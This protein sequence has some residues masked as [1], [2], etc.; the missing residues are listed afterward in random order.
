[1]ASLATEVHEISSKIGILPVLSKQECA[2]LIERA[3]VL[4]AWVDAPV[5]VAAGQAEVKSTA[6]LAKIIAQDDYPELFDEVYPA[7][8]KRLE[9]LTIVG[10]TVRY[11]VSW[12]HLI[13]YGTNGHFIPHRDAFPTTPRYVW[14][15]LSL[16]CYLNDSFE[17]G[18][19]AFPTIGMKLR[20]KIGHAVLFPST[21]KHGG[22]V[23]TAGEKYILNFYL[24]DP[25]GIGNDTPPLTMYCGRRGQNPQIGPN[26]LE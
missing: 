22:N 4:Q 23:V 15:K 8:E 7:I 13:R 5:H 19:T 2:R 21:Y 24:G 26:G 25:V 10:D 6:R 16:V 17:G 14:R 12:I 1:M 11:R 18:E 9:P 20:P 3:N